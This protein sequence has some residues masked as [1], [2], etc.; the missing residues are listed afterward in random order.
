M[1][2]RLFVLNWSPLATSAGKKGM[3]TLVMF[4]PPEIDYQRLPL[5]TLVMPLRK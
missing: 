2:T 5:R 4:P 1:V 3:V